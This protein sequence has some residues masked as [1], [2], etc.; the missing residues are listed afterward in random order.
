MALALQDITYGAIPI[1]SD[2]TITTDNLSSY[3]GRIVK[4]LI[5]IGCM[6]YQDV[7]STY[8]ISD[9]DHLEI[10]G[11]VAKAVLKDGAQPRTP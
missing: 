7:P 10:S 11:D 4:A 3:S 9:V 2:V 5:H 8:D 1:Q 6:G